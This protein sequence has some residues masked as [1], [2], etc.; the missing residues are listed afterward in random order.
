MP[1]LPLS[2]AKK[3]PQ[4]RHFLTSLPS[5]GN[6]PL[7]SWGAPGP[8]KRARGDGRMRPSGSGAGT[9]RGHVRICTL[10]ITKYKV[11]CTPTWLLGFSRGAQTRVP[12]PPQLL[13]HRLPPCTVAPSR[14]L[15]FA[16]GPVQ[17]AGGGA[18]G[19]APAPRGRGT[20]Q[21]RGGTHTS[22]QPLSPL[23]TG[24]S[25][26]QELGTHWV[27]PAR[28]KGSESVLD[29]CLSP[30]GCGTG[31][32]SQASPPLHPAP[33]PTRGSRWML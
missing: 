33:H 6:P 29:V 2:Q 27:T 11:V 7:N 26:V 22:I 28:V 24:M 32:V 13:P 15:L 25:P 17:P 20:W 12:P 9:H 10:F 4:N 30:P 19:T 8:G 14:R 18:G 16:L 3:N 5:T 23:G 21:L 1:Q 31:W